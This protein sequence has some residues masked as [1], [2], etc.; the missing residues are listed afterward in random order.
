MKLNSVFTHT[1]FIRHALTQIM[2]NMEKFE[3]N[4]AC[5]LLKVCLLNFCGKYAV[6]LSSS[7]QIF[8][9]KISMIVSD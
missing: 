3:W 4:H 7:N 9:S 2:E 6:F 5:Y 1:S 8:P